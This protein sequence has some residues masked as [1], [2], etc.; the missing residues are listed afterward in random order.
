MIIQG[1]V[2]AKARVLVA[3]SIMMAATIAAGA[4]YAQKTDWV[5][6]EIR[7]INDAEG[8]VTIRHEPLAKL[9]MPGMTMVFTARDKA[10]LRDIKVGDKVRFIAE[11]SDGTFYVIEIAK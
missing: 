6:G 2:K 9:D 7:R 10:V 5:E 4:A 11:R 1:I 3:A 8:K